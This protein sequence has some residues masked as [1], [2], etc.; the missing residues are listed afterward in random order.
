MAA[1]DNE[2]DV[3]VDSRY[4][5]LDANLQLLGLISKPPP[6]QHWDGFR[7]S[8]EVALPPQMRGSILAAVCENSPWLFAQRPEQ[9]FKNRLAMREMMTKILTD[10]RIRSATV[11]DGFEKNDYVDRVH[12]SV[13]GA[14]K[15]GKTLAAA[16]RTMV[17]SANWRR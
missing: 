11:C 1:M 5:N 14:A 17:Q 15:V 4:P 12:L 7:R 16:I 8:L 13:D 10:L 6:P 2:I 9:D 3:P